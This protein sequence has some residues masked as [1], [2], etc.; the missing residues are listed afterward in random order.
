MR[1]LFLSLSRMPPFLMLL[2]IVGLAVTATMLYM[3]QS[4]EK[5]N[6]IT[7]MK[8]AAEQEKNQKGQVVY[9]AIR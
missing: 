6:Q 9:A 1:N 2:I 3:Q 7:Q 4:N 5:Q 8:N